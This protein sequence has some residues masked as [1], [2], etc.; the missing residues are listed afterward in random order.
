MYFRH[1]DGE[2]GQVRDVLDVQEGL[3]RGVYSPD[4]C[5]GG[6]GWEGVD[7]EFEEIGVKVEVFGEF[8]GGGGL[9]FWGGG[10]AGG[11]PV[12]F[13][14]GGFVRYDLYP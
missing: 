3:W 10:P 1:L 13:W 6:V 5:A 2:I 14:D 12:V 7:I 8:G 11:L 9:G 4:E